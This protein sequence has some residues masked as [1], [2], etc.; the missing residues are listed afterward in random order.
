M[1]NNMPTLALHVLDFLAAVKSK[2]NFRFL[3]FFLENFEPS[4]N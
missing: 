3:C 2:K 1:L 4:D